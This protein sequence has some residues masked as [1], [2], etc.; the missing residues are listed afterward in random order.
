VYIGK[1]EPY[2]HQRDAF[3]HTAHLAY[4]ALFMEQGTGKTKVAIDRTVYNF[5]RGKIQSALI[6]CPKSLT[7]TWIE[8]IVTHCPDRV[9]PIVALWDASLNKATVKQLETV[10]YNENPKQL[11]FL[12]MN[13]EGIRTPKANKLAHW[14]IRRYKTHTICDESSRI[15]TVSA[16]QSIAAHGIADHSTAKTILTGTP[17][18][19]AA[20][21]YS[22]L[23]FLMREP[24]GFTNYY[25]FRAR[26]CVLETKVIRIA[27][28]QF[29]KRTKEWTKT[30]KIIQITGA[31]NIEELKKKLMSFAFFVKKADC[32]DLPDKIYHERTTKLTP[33]GLRLYK[34]IAKNIVA[35]IEEDRF[36]TTEIALT[37]LLRLQQVVGGFLP[38]DDDEEATPIPGSNP[39]IDLLAE[40]IEQFP[41]P[42]IIWARFKAE[43]LAIIRLLRA[44]TSADKIG[45]ITGRVK[46]DDREDNRRDFQ[47]GQ[48][49][50]LVCT[51][52][53]AGYGYTLTAAENEIYFSNTFSHEHREQSED[54][55]HRIG[56][57][58]HVNIIDLWCPVP[59]AKIDVDMKL[60]QSLIEKKD[61]AAML[62][63]VRSLIE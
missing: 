9:A 40:T 51:Q 33:D 24:L 62:T 21:Y 4:A 2:A 23:R 36:I 27:K 47:S 16:K 48:K 17:A 50:F 29:D 53:C 14:F 25:S 35:E 54:R 44:I 8:E 32:L 11:T 49:D 18:V 30:R 38:S 63:D 3:N 20:D 5:E 56:Q 55:A 59:A 1:T 12:I 42:T 57:T 41:G 37:K 7:A 22:Q 61:M 10:L 60:K 52:S 28:P 15:K 58:K 34:D 43:H 46:K 39:K 6:L 26:Y 13:I 19:T 31:K 45:E